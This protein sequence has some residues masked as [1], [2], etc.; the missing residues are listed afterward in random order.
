MRLGALFIA[1]CMAIIAAAAG[2]IVYLHLG[3]STIEAATVAAGT[4]IALVLYNMISSRVGLRS[5]VGHQLADLSRG[6][7]D[8]ARQV[9]ELG[10]RVAELERKI[11]TAGDHARAV[12]DPLMTEVAELGTSVKRLEQ[13]LEGHQ[14]TL[15]VL[16]RAASKSQTAEPFTGTSAEHATSPSDG[17]DQDRA[18]AAARL[19]LDLPAIRTA[20]DANRID[21]YLQPIVTLPQRK[22]RYYEATSRLR[23]EHGETLHASAFIPR[24]ESSGLMPQIDKLVTFRCVQLVRR[25]LLKNRDIGMFCNLSAKTLTDPAFFSQLLEFLAANRAIAPSLVLQL[26]HTAVAAMGAA[27]HEGLAALSERGFHLSVDHL[28]TLRL[29]PAELANRGFRYVKVHSDL[30]LKGV[31]PAPADAAAAELSDR[32]GCFGIDLIVDRIDDEKSVMDL[33]DHDVRLGQGSLFSPPRP[34][35]PEALLAQP[36]LP[37][38]SGGE[39]SAGAKEATPLRAP[40]VDANPSRSATEIAEPAAAA[41]IASGAA[42]SG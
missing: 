25:L 27:E 10:R 8:V 9:A 31:R 39:P 38:A 33:L 2:A 22:V 32:L 20:I 21:L 6:G 42:A 1:I 37:D 5:V 4:F 34:V 41:P 19:G 12:T 13:T 3:V 14:T 40:A 23:N 26:T 11:E 7:A 35:R 36:D 30:L 29:D 18:P 16:A 15:H 28:T 24:A 17:A